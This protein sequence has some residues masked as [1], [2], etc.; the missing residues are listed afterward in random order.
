MPHKLCGLD[1]AR[2]NYGPFFPGIE[3]L[4]F[5]GNIYNLEKLEDFDGDYFSAEA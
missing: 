1:N 5:T 2:V 3:E 4:K